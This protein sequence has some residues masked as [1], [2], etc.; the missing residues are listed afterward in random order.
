MKLLTNLLCAFLW[1]KIFVSFVAKNF[2]DKKNEVSEGKK[3][4]GLRDRGLNLVFRVWLL[5]AIDVML[6][7]ELRLEK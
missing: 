6:C 5:A 7:K 3:K 4:K 1:T 2:A